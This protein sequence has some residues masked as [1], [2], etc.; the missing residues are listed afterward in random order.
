M[1][2]QP[3]AEVVYLDEYLDERL[4][5]RWAARARHPAG[6]KRGLDQAEV[7]RKSLEDNRRNARKGGVVLRIIRDEPELPPDNEA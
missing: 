6:K 5:A 4:R 7:R 1:E 3:D 2:E